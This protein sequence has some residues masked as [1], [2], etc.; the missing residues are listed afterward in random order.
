[1]MTSNAIN[2]ILMSAYISYIPVNLV[3]R[4]LLNIKGLLPVLI[5]FSIISHMNDFRPE[6]VTILTI[7]TV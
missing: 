6:T 1:M 7:S 4:I 5:I 3:Q 2:H